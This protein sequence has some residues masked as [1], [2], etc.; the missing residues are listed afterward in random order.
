M[1]I[2]VVLMGMGRRSISVL[3]LAG[4]VASL[5]FVI[6]QQP[7]AATHEDPGGTYD[8]TFPIIGDV[9]YSDTFWACRDGCSRYHQAT[10]IMTYGYKG[11]PVVAVRS[12]VVTSTDWYHKGNCCAIWSIDHG[13]GWESRYIHMNNDTPFTDDGNGWGFA[14][15]VEVGAYVEEG[16]LIGW[17]GD[18]GNAESV[19]A[20]LHFQLRHDG[21]WVNPYPILNAADRTLY[22]RIAGANR[23]ETAAMISELAFP[24][25]ADTVFIA[26]GSGFADAMS[27]G[28]AAVGENGPILLT[29]TNSLPGET[30]S[31]LNRLNPTNI[32]ILG[33]E[34]V[35]DAGVGSALSAYGEV[36][37]LAG[38]NRY[39]TSAAI[40]AAYFDPGGDV[41][42]VASGDS[43]PDAIAGAP[44]AAKDG[45]P[46][47]LVESDRIPPAIANE[48]LRLEP[49][50]ITILGGEGVVSPIVELLLADYAQ[51]GTVNRLAGSNRYAT[52]AAISRQTHPSGSATVY[53]AT[54]TGFADALT[55]VT[56]ARDTDAPLLL[57]G[58]TLGG[59][60]IAEIL[61]L[62]ATNVVVLG[63]P[64]AV[65]TTVDAG[66]WSI[67]NDNDMPIWR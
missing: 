35:V 49:A 40:S 60:T 61:R 9:Y 2:I 21:V 57:V 18:S 23:Y 63:G 22:P 50:A 66:I 14:E 25:G 38:A 10:D 55:G 1:P 13:D 30:V 29:R 54:G 20:H 36:T 58:D 51:S 43:F 62:G 42:Y 32:V 19:V 4:L 27:G 17:V 31:E 41:A 64:G 6:S 44:A 65:S 5:P 26:T 59:D 7:A 3:L 53:L 33:G 16:Q 45:A 48:L 47:L 37:R 46:L 12:G 24:G 15:G 67:F 52:A 56:I 8:I 34:G 11:L 39:E 28:P